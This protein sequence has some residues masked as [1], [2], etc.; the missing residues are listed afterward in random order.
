[1]PHRFFHKLLR[2]GGDFAIHA[3]FLIA[4]LCLTTATCFG[5]ELAE[6]RIETDRHDFTQS[7]KTVGRGNSQLEFG[8]TYFYSDR[9]GEIEDAHT[10]PESLLRVGIT[11]RTEL[12]LRTNYAWVFEEEDRREGSEDIRFAFK[13]ETSEAEGLTPESALELRFTFPTGGDAW[14]TNQVCLLYTSPSPRDLSTSRMP[15][16]A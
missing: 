14:S 1:M 11:E 10:G 9:E 3:G 7:T 2:V 15:S 6:E 12:R 5:Q 13:T 16:S 4:I 8:Y